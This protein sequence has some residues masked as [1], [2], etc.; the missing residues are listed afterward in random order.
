MHSL[1]PKLAVIF[2]P[3]MLIGNTPRSFEKHHSDLIDQITARDLDGALRSID[4]HIGRFYRDLQI[5]LGPA[6]APTVAYLERYDP[7]RPMLVERRQ[8]RNGGHSHPSQEG[9]TRT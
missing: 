6:S 1:L 7:A 2:Y 3:Q 5:R 8:G 4:A 9:F